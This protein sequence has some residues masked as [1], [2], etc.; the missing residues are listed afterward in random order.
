MT[1]LVIGDIGLPMLWLFDRLLRPPMILGTVLLFVR[2]I[3]E[4]WDSRSESFAWD[5]RRE[6]AGTGRA[7]VEMA[8]CGTEVEAEAGGVV[9]EGVERGRRE[10]VIELELESVPNPEMALKGAGDWDGDGDSVL[11]LGL[12]SCV[13][14]L[15]GERPSDE[16]GD[17]CPEA[18]LSA[19]ASVAL[20]VRTVCDECN[21]SDDL[22]CLSNGGVGRLSATTAAGTGVS[23]GAGCCVDE[24]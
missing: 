14:S 3:D 20:A 19:A 7:V 11:G 12:G 4:A 21:R 17:E 13:M 18:L 22:V 9:R 5:R 8:R 6:S 10:V 15:A 16:A 23:A 1:E 24:I 2:L